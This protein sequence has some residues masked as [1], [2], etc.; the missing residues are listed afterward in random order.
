MISI[1]VIE[2][3]N[4]KGALMGMRN[5]KESWGKSDSFY[6][7]DGNFI[8]GDVDHNLAMTLATAGSDHGKFLRQ[9]FVCMNVTA[10][11]YWWKEFDTYKVGTVANSTSTMHKLGSRPLEVEDFSWDKLTDRR[12]N[13]LR[14][15]N[16]TIQLW[17]EETIVSNKHELWRE[18]IQDLPTS[19]N[20]MRTVTLNYEVLRNIYFARRNH[21]LSEWHEFCEMIEY[22]PYSELITTER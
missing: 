2:V 15:Y 6:D 13:W 5:P 22:M 3:T 19:F 9:I 18:M 10:P 17:K 7:T 11:L 14:E 20:Q 8:M 21:K 12:L 16:E 4:F 1:D